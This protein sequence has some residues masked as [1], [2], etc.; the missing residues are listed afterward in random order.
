[1]QQATHAFQRFSIHLHASPVK[2]L[3]RISQI[4]EVSAFSHFSLI[5]KDFQRFFSIFLQFL[6]NQSVVLAM[7]RNPENLQPKSCF[8]G[9]HGYTITNY[10]TIQVKMHSLQCQ[11]STAQIIIIFIYK[12]PQILSRFA[13]ESRFPSTRTYDPAPQRPNLDYK[14]PSI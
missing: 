13:K 6:I 2:K 5:F 12:S 8:Q 14:A 7:M 1:M 4:R 9:L 10:A 11:I 3:R